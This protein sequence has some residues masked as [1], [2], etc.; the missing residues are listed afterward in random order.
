MVEDITGAYGGNWV[1]DD[2][3]WY[4]P[5]K[6]HDRPDCVLVKGESMGRTTVLQ[7]LET[8]PFCIKLTPVIIEG[9]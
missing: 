9:I 4:G 8:T 1:G 7:A 2:R 5:L 6:V 3:A